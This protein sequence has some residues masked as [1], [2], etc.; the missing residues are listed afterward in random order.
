MQTV[1][2]PLFYASY[3]AASGRLQSEFALILSCA[4]KSITTFSGSVE[5]FQ[6][7]CDI[8]WVYHFLNLYIIQPRAEKDVQDNKQLMPNSY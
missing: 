6:S 7:M 4:L 1:L 3:A 2:F 5:Y 8:L